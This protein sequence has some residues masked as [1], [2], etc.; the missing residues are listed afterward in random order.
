MSEIKEYWKP[1]V[2]ADIVVVDS[3]AAKFRED[4]VFLNILLIKRSDK[5]AA[6]PNCWALPGGFLDRG[7]SIEQCAVRELKEETG[8]EARMLAPV[9]VFSKPDR[10]PRGQVISHAFF[11]LV[12]STDENPLVVKAGDDAKEFGLFNLKGHLDAENGDLTVRLRCVEN[13]AIISFKAK[14]TRGWLGLINTEITYDEKDGNTKLAFDHAEII[15]RTLL[16]IPGLVNPDPNYFGKSK[17]E[18][19]EAPDACSDAELKKRLGNTIKG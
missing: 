7:E 16:R 2:T 8:I 5:T 13:G 15:A 6:F 14:F 3:H 19:E 4:G 11:T 10:D 1:A 12:I 18:H 17:V 9:E